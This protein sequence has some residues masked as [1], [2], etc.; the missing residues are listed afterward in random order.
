MFK[1][2]FVLSDALIQPHAT[3]SFIAIADSLLW[4][5]AEEPS[6]NLGPFQYR[7]LL[8][9]NQVR[10]LELDPTASS[11]RRIS[12]TMR[13]VSLDDMPTYHALSYTWGSALFSEMIVCNGQALS[14]TANLRHAMLRLLTENGNLVLWID[15]VCIDQSNTAERGQQVR[16]M[17][18]IFQQ[19]E[20]V[21]LSGSAWKQTRV[22][23]VRSVHFIIC[24]LSPNA[25]PSRCDGN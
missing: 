8:H 6:E 25:L 23:K 4:N 15:A 22:L 2:N 11:A 7:P 13:A 10:L 19:A 1:F 18:R 20:K 3:I 14:V 12:G 21:F 17:K 16:L 9:Q 5:M 24:G